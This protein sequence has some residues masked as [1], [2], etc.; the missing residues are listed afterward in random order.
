MS[1]DLRIKTDRLLND[2][3]S[4]AQIGRTPDGGV[5]RPALSAADLEARRWFRARAQEAGLTV[6]QDGIANVSAS[7]PAAAGAGP[8]VMIGS[9]TDSV[10]N[11]GRY[12][13]ALGVVAA[14]EA[15]RTIKEAQLALPCNLE[16]MSFTDEE[17]RWGSMLG[18]RGLA[19]RL[20]AGDFSH[21]RGGKDAFAAAMK[22]AGITR[23]S[24]TDAKRAAGTIKAW[25]E[26]HIEQG[27]R[28]EEAGNAVGI[29]TGIAGIASYWLTFKGRADHAGT[30]PVD[31]RF[32]A[33]RGVSEFVRQSRDLVMN[34][35]SGGMINCGMVE[36]P[37]GAFN[38]V[39]ERARLALE[40]RHH[41]AHMLDAM[42]EALLSMA[43][44][45]VEVEGLGLEVEQVG[46]VE[47]VTLDRDIH[48]AIESACE[49]VGLKHMHL[50]SYAAHDTQIMA[51][52]TR[53]GMFFVPSAG[54]TS[55]S[56]R[57]FTSDEDCV[58][59]AN[60]LLHT[61]LKLAEEQPM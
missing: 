56:P 10:P 19:G 15:V 57:E 28:L 36:V 35:F 34:R 8:V 42:R 25:V 26:V 59:A 1:A 53:A 37:G 23:G 21:P 47:P 48:A 2:L 60:V 32:D 40:F 44:H 7:L 24:A 18:S 4:L 3:A 30:T 54:G 38:I 9:H 61:V 43:L 22:A 41:E 49:T 52:L 50:P 27:T 45:V 51:G 12:D 33:L 39:P 31:R 55:H 29:V 11:G 5:N 20:N 16:V 13:G 58:N 46:F 17:G 14:L 6:Q